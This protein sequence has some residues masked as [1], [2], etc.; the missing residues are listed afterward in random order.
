MT[1]RYDDAPMPAIAGQQ[2]QIGEQLL[3][4]GVDREIDAIARGH[5]GDL[6]RCALVKV[7]FDVRISLSELANHLRQHIS[8]LSVSGADG[9]RAAA[10]ALLLVRQALD[11]LNFLQDLLGAVDDPLTRRRDPR[12]GAALAQ[13]DRK[14]ELVL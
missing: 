4:A 1:L 8:S 3:R 2:D 11:A 14:T 9:Q 13:K 7:Q 6:L 10:V 12:Q 5:V